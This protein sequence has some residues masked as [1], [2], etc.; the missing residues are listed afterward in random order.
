MSG[1]SIQGG[2]A[3]IVITASDQTAGGIRSAENSMEGMQT[4]LSRSAGAMGAMDALAGQLQARFVGLAAGAATI[5]VAFRSLTESLEKS[6]EGGGMS[7]GDTFAKTFA[8][9]FQSIPVVGAVAKLGDVFVRWISGSLEEE[10][11]ARAAAERNRRAFAEAERDRTATAF[12]GD[13]RL[14]L[15][16]GEVDDD[17]R[18]IQR[19]LRANPI[20]LGLSEE[21]RQS[22]IAKANIESNAFRTR[23]QEDAQRQG[24]FDLVDPDSRRRAIEDINRLVEQDKQRRLRAVDDEFARRAEAIAQE[25]DRREASAEEIARR[26][27]D[28]AFRIASIQ[29]SLA[30]R[31]ADAQLAAESEALGDTPGDRAR[32]AEIA[33]QRELLRIEEQLRRSEEQ[34][35]RDRSLSDDERERLLAGEQELADIQRQQIETRLQLAQKRIAEGSQQADAISSQA[36]GTFSALAASRVS[37]EARWQNDLLS[38]TRQIAKNTQAIGGTFTP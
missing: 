4:K 28:A 10:A 32:S 38:A 9:G 22:E 23:L 8:E 20:D 12:G 19:E 17:I 29:E 31:L 11:E 37:N 15:L 16:S 21:L 6:L 13:V 5:N 24:V 25:Q 3:S 34:I 26:E 1:A 14:R 35:V 33:A 30:G 18:Q 27:E 2:G 7:F 36:F